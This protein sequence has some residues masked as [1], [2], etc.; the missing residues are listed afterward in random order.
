M[1]KDQNLKIKLLTFF[2]I[3]SVIIII[4]M[5]YSL[6]KLNNTKTAVENVNK[7]EI[8][9]IEMTEENYNKYNSNGYQFV[10]LDMQ[11]NNNNTVTIKGRVYKEKELLMY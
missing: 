10:I 9:Y 11:E 1:E 2:L 6:F 7:S 8:N 4:L 3:L 5:G